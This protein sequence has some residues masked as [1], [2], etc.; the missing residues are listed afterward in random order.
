[1]VTKL[2]KAY[3]FAKFA[4]KEDRGFTKVNMFTRKDMA[5]NFN[6]IVSVNNFASFATRGN[7]AITKV[8][9]I[10]IKYTVD[11]LNQV[12][13]YSNCPSNFNSKVNLNFMIKPMDY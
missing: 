1:M 11:V 10:I 12:N 4:I 9:R 13:Y 5:A 2:V 8:N 6:Q 7:K 3:N